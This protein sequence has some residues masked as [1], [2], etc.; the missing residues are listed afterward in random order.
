MS[1]LRTFQAGQHGPLSQKLLNEVAAARICL[2]NPRKKAA[3]DASLR[4]E[5]ESRGCRK[6]DEMAALRPTHAARRTWPHA[7]AAILTAVAAVVGVG[8]DRVAGD[9]PP[10]A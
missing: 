2:L 1:H 7:D 3:Y 6:S 8:A 10:E 9:V 4:T 5:L